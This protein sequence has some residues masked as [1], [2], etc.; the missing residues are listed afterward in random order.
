MQVTSELYR[1][2]LAT[3]NY[4]FEI[5]VVIGDTGSLITENNER[6][7]FGADNTGILVSSGSPDSGY[8]ENMIWSLNTKQSMFKNMP[9]SG[10]AISSEIEL[11]MM[12]PSGEIARRAQIKPYF[13]AKGTITN[14]TMVV[15]PETGQETVVY[16]EEEVV[17][18]W[19]QKGVFYVDTREYSANTDALR[20]MTLR[21]FDAMLMA[22]T[23][24]PE[25]NEHTYPLL[26]ITMVEHIASYIGV[27]VDSRTYEI[28]TDGYR[29]SLPV[30]YSAREVLCMI[31]GAYC[32]T[33][34]ISDIG[35]LRLVQLNE[36]P[37][38]TAVLI[39]HSGS[40]IVFGTGDNATRI[41][42]A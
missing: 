30:G 41:L 27:S 26:D 13:R 18:E 9:E 6:I 32:G 39:D 28:M 38:E 4:E 40:A 17:S 14:A 2:I 12:H 21:G 11:R 37:R 20:I 3:N 15:D 24:Y 31:A 36:L 34:V 35:E 19:I 8:R 22:E 42:V 29:F 25:D 33:F 10:N 7:L 1:R 16:E 23:D 5:A